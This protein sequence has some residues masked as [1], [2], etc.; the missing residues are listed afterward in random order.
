MQIIISVNLSFPFFPVIVVSFITC[1]ILPSQSF[2]LRSQSC[3]IRHLYLCILLYYDQSCLI[4]NNGNWYASPSAANYLAN[5]PTFHVL[6]SQKET[7]WL[8]TIHLDSWSRRAQ[9]L[10]KF[11]LK[12]PMIFHSTSI[13]IFV[14]FNPTLFSTLATSCCCCWS[15]IAI[16]SS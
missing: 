5:A 6:I 8:K 10:H 11:K 3:C 13:S 14:E 12:C 9:S 2:P 7:S 15:S 1:I 4:C 16:A